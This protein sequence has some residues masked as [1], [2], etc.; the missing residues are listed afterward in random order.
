MLQKL[1]PW[2]VVLAL[3]GGVLLFLAERQPE[4]AALPTVPDTTTGQTIKQLEANGTDPLA[5][6]YAYL[7]LVRETGDSAYYQRIEALLDQTDP[8][9]A[10]AL[11]SAIAAGRHDFAAA[12]TQAELAISGNP[13]EPLYYG[14][15]ADALIELGQYEA[16][17]AAVQTMV[18]LRPDFAAYS[19]IAYLRELYGDIA[20][21]KEALEQAIA[22]GSAYP[23]NLAWAA[24]QIGH[25]ELRTS[26]TAAQRQY[27]RALLYQENFPAA[28][29]GL[30]KAAQAEQNLTAAEDYYQQALTQ[31]PLAEYAIALG[32]VTGDEHYYDLA[33][34]AFT[35]SRQA[36]TNTDLELARFWLTHDRQ[37]EAA[38]EL[39][40]AAYAARPSIFAADVYALA[41]YKNNRLPEA[42]VK[43]NE[44]LRLGAFDPEIIA[45]AALITEALS[46]D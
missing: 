8:T 44:A 1:L 11:R 39:A 41:L 18:D 21:A 29:A 46:N 26:P 13:N 9:A 27:E 43:M 10:A 37:L 35:A 14:L 28:L 2:L 30:G 31:Q 6:A 7:Q 38:L 17:T 12:Q 3:F 32:D 16:A 34:S 5:L 25:L 4:T 24:T 22:G 33:E 19:R 40:T 20:G 15:L 23:E 36:G 42:E 45:H